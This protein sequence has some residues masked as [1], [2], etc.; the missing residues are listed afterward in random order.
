MDKSELGPTGHYPDGKVCPHDKGETVVA[1][2]AD[3]ERGLVF[4]NYGVPTKWVAFPPVQARALAAELL[5]WAEKAE[6]AA[7]RCEKCY[8][9]GQ[10]ADTRDQE[11]WKVWLEMPLQSAIAVQM[12]LVRPIPCPVCKGSG[13]APQGGE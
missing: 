12:G 10:V 8:G 4:M 9:C 7:A 2:G 6:R 3:L 5:Q 11:P 1:I 13:L